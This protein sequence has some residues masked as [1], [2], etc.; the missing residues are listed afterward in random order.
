MAEHGLILG[1]PLGPRGLGGY[2]TIDGDGGRAGDFSVSGAFEVRSGNSYA[3]AVTGADTR[4]FHFVLLSTRPGEKRTRAVAT[5][6]PGPRDRHVTLSISAGV[7]RVTNFA[8]EQGHDR[9]NGVA[10]LRAEIRP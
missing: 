8:F 5:W 2:L 6:T 4:G 1:D 9:T 7:E 10:Q 3:S